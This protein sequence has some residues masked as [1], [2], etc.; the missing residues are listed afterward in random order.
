[1]KYLFRSVKNRKVAGVCAGLAEYFNLDPSLVRIVWLSCVLLAGTGIL[2][3]LI[4]WLIIPPNPNE[5]ITQKFTVFTRSPKNKIIAGVCGGLGE[6]FQIDPVIFRLI[7]LLLVI[8]CGFGVI[9]YFILWI[10]IPISK[11]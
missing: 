6:Y 2:I 9:L 11:A 7:F 3:Y 1:M 5:P 8:G 10:C 4:A